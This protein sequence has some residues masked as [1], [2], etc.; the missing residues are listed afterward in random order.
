MSEKPTKQVK[1]NRKE[2]TESAPTSHF[3]MRG[4]RENAS[5][6]YHRN[7]NVRFRRDANV[8]NEQ[9]RPKA[10]SSSCMG[11]P[12]VHASH[13]K[14]IV[15]TFKKSSPNKMLYLSSLLH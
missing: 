1:G 8:K 4:N 7:D 13:W 6:A 14:V 2:T 9:R 11:T 12:P 15:E 3:S 5:V 10:D